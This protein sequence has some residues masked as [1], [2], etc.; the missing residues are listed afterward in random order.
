MNNLKLIIYLSIA[1]IISFNINCKKEKNETLILEKIEINI[2]LQNNTCNCEI[3]DKTLSNVRNYTNIELL[4]TNQTYNLN[5]TDPIN[6]IASN[7][8]KVLN[9]H[10]IL[11]QKNFLNNQE[12]LLE[13]NVLEDPNI[14]DLKI[15]NNNNHLTEKM[16]I[17]NQNI[18]NKRIY[19]II[20]LTIFGSL[21]FFMAVYLDKKRE[22]DKKIFNSDVKYHLMKK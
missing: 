11:N 1:I 6:E 12:I 8:D 4:E 10:I 3:F 14:D 16:K 21:I 9:P 17:I 22:Y 13:R 15:L 20:F 5:G 7:I 2:D 18:K 19:L